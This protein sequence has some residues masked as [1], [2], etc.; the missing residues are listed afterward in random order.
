M[1][2][3]YW[4]DQVWCPT[5]GAKP[6]DPCVSV[7]TQKTTSLPHKARVERARKTEVPRAPLKRKTPL[8]AKKRKGSPGKTWT[9]PSAATRQRVEKRAGRRCE[10]RT[11]DCVDVPAAQLHHRLLR[12]QGGGHSDE[13]LLL[14][15]DPCHAYIHA[16]PK[17][18][19]RLG[20]L[21]RS[22]SSV[23]AYTPGRRGER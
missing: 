1:A 16:H 20:W 9:N 18:G 22:G 19:Y 2:G 3:D 17:E 14:V 7:W 12:S 6:D 21:L 15:C 5:C 11:P 4:P 23:T 8:T 10:A 13:N